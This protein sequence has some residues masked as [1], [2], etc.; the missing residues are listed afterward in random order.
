[1]TVK[2]LIWLTFILAIFGLVMI[3]SAGLYLS[4]KNFGTNY[5]YFNH[6]FLFGFLPGLILF[7][8]A[9]KTDYKVWRKL[10]LPLILLSI[11]FLILVFIPG[12]GRAVGGAKRWVDFFDIFSFQPTEIL[13]LTLIIY[14]ASWLSSKMHL[15]KDGIG[16]AAAFL[17]IIFFIGI[18]IT[19][20]PDIGTLA[21]IVAI[22]IL[23][24]FASGG[25]FKH[26]LG[27]ILLIAVS[28]T[29]LTVFSPYRFNRLFVFLNPDFDV[30]GVGYHLNQSLIA[31]GKGGVFGLGFGKGEQKLGF[32][33]EPVG[34]SIFA[35]VG[36]E[37][38]FVGMI[39]VLF[40]IL[41]FVIV[42]LKIARNTRD[43]FASLFAVGL[44]SWVGLQSFINIASLSG[45]IPLTGIPLPFV[46]YGGTSLAVLM[47]AS[48]ILVNIGKKA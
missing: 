23:M 5:Y 27:I 39:S 38:G 48:G 11:G 37:L 9:S 46:S 8:I 15:R 45:L 6:Q 30:Q 33:P 3:S 7:L 43:K 1:M 20:Q 22:A 29:L 14:L 47:A 12:F 4:Q 13:K 34:D 28:F 10:S 17:A 21:I 42:S 19:A 40:L 26:L 44:A 2:S 41:F 25:G 24:F 18:F 16:S 36:E 35:V 31:I 32:L